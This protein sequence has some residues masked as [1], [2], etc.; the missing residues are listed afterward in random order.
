[1]YK[2]KTCK[3]NGVI[4]WCNLAIAPDLNLLMMH[5]NTP[6]LFLKQILDVNNISNIFYFSLRW[7][8]IIAKVLWISKAYNAIYVICGIELGEN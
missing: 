7:L 2:K 1:M 5:C 3:G 8:I 4:A 6:S